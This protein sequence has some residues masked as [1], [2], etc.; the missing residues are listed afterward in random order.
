MESEHAPL[1]HAVFDN[2]GHVPLPGMLVSRLGLGRARW[3]STGYDSG[4]QLE[5][6]PTGRLDSDGA[7]EDL[8]QALGV[9]E[10]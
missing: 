2:D 7:A 8:A 1:W 6:G 5:A 9:M 10:E 3:C 4:A